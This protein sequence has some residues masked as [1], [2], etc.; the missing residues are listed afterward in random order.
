MSMTIIL[1]QDARPLPTKQVTAILFS[2]WPFRRCCS[3]VVS[4]HQLA[5]W[6]RNQSSRRL[7]FE[8]HG[9]EFVFSY[10]VTKF[11]LQSLTA[12]TRRMKQRLEPLQLYWIVHTLMTSKVPR[13]IEVWF[14]FQHLTSFSSADEPGP[15]VNVV[16]NAHFRARYLDRQQNT[17]SL[18]AHD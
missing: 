5:F 14:R 10:T 11:S 12:M 1:L 15:L 9:I 4:T 18:W 6:S 8:S 2:T 17:S 3:C 7:R 13:V 16:N